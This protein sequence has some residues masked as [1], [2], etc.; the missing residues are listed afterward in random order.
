MVEK[1]RRWS[2]FAKFV[3]IEQ[4]IVIAESHLG[5][6]T[7]VAPAGDRLSV[8]ASKTLQRTVG[9]CQWRGKV[10]CSR[11]ALT[12][13]MGK[14]LSFRATPEERE[15][16]RHHSPNALPNHQAGGSAVEGGI[17]PQ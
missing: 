7:V 6:V 17:K 16:A 2:P 3:D 11:L 14:A 10:F 8:Q 4:N 12:F 15:T 9:E 13:T 1:E 5:V